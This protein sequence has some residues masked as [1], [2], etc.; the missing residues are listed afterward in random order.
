MKESYAL[1]TAMKKHFYDKIH[2]A[3]THNGQQQET[4]AVAHALY[5]VSIRLN[6]HM[7]LTNF[8]VVW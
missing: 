6:T 3:H 2:T 8:Y 4:T 7:F 5:L 1:H